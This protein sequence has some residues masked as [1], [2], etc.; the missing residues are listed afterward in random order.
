[1]TKSTFQRHDLKYP[2]I[3]AHG[4]VAEMC[5]SLAQEVYEEKA[6][7]NDFYAQYPDRDD[8][9]RTWAPE[10]RQ[11][12]RECLGAMLGRPDVDEATKDKIFEALCLDK[13]LPKSGTSMTPMDRTHTGRWH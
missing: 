6:S 11:E 3:T 8:F 9:V 13:A 10:F 1:M 12:A 2:N 7:K 4:M 5:V